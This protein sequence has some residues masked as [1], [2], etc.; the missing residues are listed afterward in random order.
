MLKLTEDYVQFAWSFG[1]YK[2]QNYYDLD[3]PVEILDPG[4]HNNSSGPDFFNARIKM[5]QTIWAGNIEIHLKASDWYR[6]EHHKDLA[7]DS[8]ILHVVLEN[9][10]P[11]FR[12]NSEIVPAIEISLHEKQLHD[13]KELVLSNTDLPCGNKIGKIEKVFLHDWVSKMMISRLEEKTNHVFATLEDNKFDWE[14]TFYRYLGKSFGFKVNSLP[15]SMLMETVPLKLLLRSRKNLRTINALLFGQA[16]FLNDVISGDAYYDSLHRE[17]LGLQP[18]LPARTLQTH[19]WKFM[20]LRPANFPTV[21]IS[22]FASLV[23][24][25]FPIFADILECRDI[26]QLRSMFMINTDRYWEDH[27][28]FGKSAKRRKYRLGRDSA[29]SIILN[30]VLP[31]LFT[32]AKFRMKDELQDRVIRF[33]GELPPE[34]NEFINQWIRAGINPESAFD[35]Q[36]LLHL[37]KNYCKERRC[38][39][40]VVGSRIIVNGI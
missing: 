15:F 35:T 20:R 37:T 10:K 18:V 33:L 31:V 19:S 30:A 13:Y 1:L 29:D 26:N 3:G 23:V 34:K 25:R 11:V 17:F 14:E 4:E 7:Y 40:C 32:Y 38:L 6:H 9:D 28:L 21:R 8:V 2:I 12:M 16:G 27:M 24:R 36:A 5:G 22:Q 39:D